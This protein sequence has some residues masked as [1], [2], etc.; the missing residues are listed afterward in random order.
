MSRSDIQSF[1][2]KLQDDIDAGK[3]LL[4]QSVASSVQFNDTIENSVSRKKKKEDDDE[5]NDPNAT[6][7]KFKFVAP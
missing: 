4:T 2:A 6:L 5:E 1:L 3:N 7:N